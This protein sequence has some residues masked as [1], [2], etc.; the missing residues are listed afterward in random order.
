M[1]KNNIEQM[2]LE[3]DKKIQEAILENAL[4]EPFKDCYFRIINSNMY[5]TENKNEYKKIIHL[6]KDGIDQKVN[7]K[8]FRK[9]L[10]IY[11]VT[12]EIPVNTGN[13]YIKLPADIGTRKSWGDKIGILSVTYISGKYAI[14]IDLEIKDKIRDMF[15]IKNRDVTD[16]EMSTYTSIYETKNKGF[17]PMVETFNFKSHQIGFYGGNMKL[18]DAEEIDRIM[19]I[20]KGE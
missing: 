5:P 8:D 2:R 14:W 13:G 9:C 17:K 11:P 20:L 4:S 16:C 1:I 6:Y 15:D 3:F 19:K 10:K 7:I 18:V 12:E